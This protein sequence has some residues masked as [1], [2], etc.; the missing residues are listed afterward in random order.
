MSTL[1]MDNVIGW[2]GVECRQENFHFDWVG[3]GSSREYNAFVVVD[4]GR[5]SIF[6]P[7]P[8]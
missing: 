2:H 3:E 7:S 4:S 6:N 1:T 5:N 8:E